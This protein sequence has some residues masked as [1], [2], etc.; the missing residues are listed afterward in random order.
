MVIDEASSIYKT[1]LV[2]MSVHAKHGLYDTDFLVN[3]FSFNNL[4]PILGE[5]DILLHF[6]RFK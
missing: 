1:W 6:N 5:F 3:V 2:T 4:L